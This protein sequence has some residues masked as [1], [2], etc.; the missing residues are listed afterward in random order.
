VSAT[1]D[2]KARIRAVERDYPGSQVWTGPVSRRWSWRLIDGT[3]GPN[4]ILTADDEEQLRGKI[5]DW[6]GEQAE[7]ADP[8][9]QA[10]VDTC[11][12]ALRVANQDSR[13]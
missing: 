5:D 4:E 9:T 6:L 7:R 3:S 1:E 8:A 13:P 12:E 2:E 11:I 10:V